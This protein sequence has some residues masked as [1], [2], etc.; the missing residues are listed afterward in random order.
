[1]ATQNGVKPIENILVALKAAEQEREAAGFA[2]ADRLKDAFPDEQEHVRQADVAV[3]KFKGLLQE[4][5][6]MYGPLPADAKS[7]VGWAHYSSAV[8]LVYAPAQAW[9]DALEKADM[10]H[11]IPAIMDESVNL[12]SVGVLVKTS[13]NFHKAVEGLIT[14]KASKPTLKYGFA[15]EKPSGL[16]AEIQK[17]KEG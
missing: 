15:V 7:A 14:E 10:A 11:Y 8:K 1:M 2:L 13:A 5:V 6:G 4:A 9:R 17:P 3:A 12:L 16:S